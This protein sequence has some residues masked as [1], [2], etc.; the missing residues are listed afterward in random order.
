MF[1][2]ILFFITKNQLFVIFK[3]SRAFIN[4]GPET[5]RDFTENLCLRVGIFHKIVPDRWG[6]GGGKPNI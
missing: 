6:P 4:H 5:A 2:L 1:N 3:P